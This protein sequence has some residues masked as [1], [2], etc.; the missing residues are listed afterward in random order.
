MTIHP[1]AGKPAVSSSLTHVPRLVSAY[2]PHHPDA[3]DARQAVAFGTSG[4]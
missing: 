2:Y 4:Q 1:L 3:S